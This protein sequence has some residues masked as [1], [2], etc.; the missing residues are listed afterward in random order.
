MAD[1]TGRVVVIGGGTMGAGIAQCLLEVGAPV[2]VVE[3][4]PETAEAALARVEH[5]LGRRY[6]SAHDPAAA[7]AASLEGLDLRVGVPEG[8]EA[9]LVI[10]AVPEEPKLKADI[11]ASAE[12]AFP[13]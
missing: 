13:K 9:A 8:A 12:A 5:G 7:V 3:S 10:E 4:S 1:A 2:T 11:L 6:K